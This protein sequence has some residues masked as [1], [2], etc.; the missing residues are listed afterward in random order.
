VYPVHLNPSVKKAA[1]KLLGKK[2]R[3]HLINPLAYPSF[4]WLMSKSYL[5]ITD[6]GGIQEEVPS[7]GKPVIVIRDVTEREEGIQAG[8]AILAGTKKESIIRETTELL[9]NTNSYS[10][11]TSNANP[12]G[13]GT[14]SSQII[15]IIE[16]IQKSTG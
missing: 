13:D 7:L 3:I 1:E 8:T 2:D 5:V 14:A 12:Y 10:Q 15:S 9:H 4:V 16:K 11:M 6:S